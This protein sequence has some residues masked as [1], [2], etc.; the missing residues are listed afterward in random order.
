[1]N[2]TWGLRPV[3]FNL[4]GFPIEA[5][6]F[7]VTLAVVLGILIY[8]IQLKKDDIKGSN[9]LYIVM[10]AIV[11]GAIGSKLPI[12]IMYWKEMYQNNISILDA[13]AGRTIIGGL[14]G[15]F[16]FTFI[17]KRFFKIKERLGNQIAIP[18]AVG[19]AIGRFGCL[20]RGCCYGKAT[21]SNWGID[22]GD[23]ILRH[24][25]QIYEIIFLIFLIGLLYY[26]KKKGVLPGQL[27]RIFLNSYLS[28]RF[29]IEFIRI[30]KVSF[31]VLTDFQWLCVISIIYMNR[32]S[33]IQLFN[34]KGGNVYEN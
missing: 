29:M 6:P 4:F 24:P 8:L 22:F 14:I 15:G 16:V 2:E 19:M 7:F 17:G 32:Y 3:L 28:F 21:Y 18:V 1:M 34:K 25:T 33:I 13:L 12:L 5:Y 30:E 31:W 10:F 23:H 27:F 9:A 11:G 20:F 26:R